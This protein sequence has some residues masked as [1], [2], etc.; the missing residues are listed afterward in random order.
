MFDPAALRRTVS[1]PRF[2][3]AALA[4]LAFAVR[5]PRLADLPLQWDEGWSVALAALPLPQLLDLTAR[6]VH[7][8]L[9]YAVLSA[10]LSALGA[11]PFAARMLSALVGTLSVPLA[12]AA[13]R[14]WWPRDR[15]ALPGVVAAVYAALAPPLVYYAGIARMYALTTPLLLLVAVG[16]ARLA[17]APPGLSGSAGS[18]T[19][20]LRGLPSALALATAVIGAVA[21]LHTFYYAGFALAGLGAAALAT[22]PGRWRRFVLWAFLCAMAM[23]PWLGYAAP[24]LATRVAER[25][26]GSIDIRA[27]PAGMRAALHAALFV[28]APV[29]WLWVPILAAVAWAL[30]GR[31]SRSDGLVVALPVALVAL[32]AAAGA[33][34]HMLAPRY[35]IVATPF[36]ALGA[37]WLVRSALAGTSAPRGPR[38]LLHASIVAAALV[39]AI[40]P[41]LTGRSYARNAEIDAPYDPAALP[42]AIVE[43]ARGDALVVFNVLSLAGAY[44]ALKAPADPPWTYA[45]LWD[46]VH[47]PPERAIARLL[48]HLGA[49]SPA[50]ASI[51]AQPAPVAASP[52]AVWFA[53][54]RG[55]A[56][57]DTAAYARWA[58]WH[59]WP[60]GSRWSGETLLRGYV[61][62]APDAVALPR[63][64]PAREAGSI[65]QFAGNVDLV[66][67]TYTA[68]ANAGRGLAVELTWSA[69]RPP[70]ADLRVFVHAYGP[71]GALVAQHDGLPAADARPVSTWGAGERILDRH[72]L[73]LPLTAPTTLTLAAGLY[74]AST[75]ARLLRPDGTDVVA[76]GDVTIDAR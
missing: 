59:L 4:L 32:G 28:D 71:D 2:V 33:Q 66:A 53:L 20:R 70:E 41:T 22:W 13:A 56:A 44:E 30:V 10:W 16:L 58:D 69:D 54:Y 11:T 73:L 21:A 14:A 50:A 26:G 1:R 49:G 48:D 75:G 19:R 29:G 65:A 37:A 25:T 63:G 40:L 76:L 62:A 27:L 31:A 55:T 64:V 18:A 7:P 35:A 47:E 5:M 57:D 24:L 61:D 6:D 17:T 38:A 45:Q 15:R 51:G 67:A 72:G 74:D 39:A 8:P 9:Y 43:A 42:S 12:F 46:P 36:L 34:A 52:A 68:R 60:I 3:V 23:V